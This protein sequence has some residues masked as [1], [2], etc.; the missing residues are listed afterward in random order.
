LVNTVERHSHFFECA[1]Q[2]AMTYAKPSQKIVTFLITDSAHLR[3]DAVRRFP[4]SVVVSGLAQK[5]I[6]IGG[7]DQLKADSEAEKNTTA[8]FDLEK[9]MEDADGFMNTLA[10]TW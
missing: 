10:E 3:Q 9:V 8:L 1:Q 7:K 6:E 4:S 5:H 2:V